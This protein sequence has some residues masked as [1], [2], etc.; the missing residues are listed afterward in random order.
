M[1]KLADLGTPRPPLQMECAIQA[2]LASNS[3]SEHGWYCSWTFFLLRHFS[4]D[5]FPAYRVLP[6][7]WLY[8]ACGYTSFARSERLSS[9]LCGLVT[10]APAFGGRARNWRAHAFIVG[11]AVVCGTR[12]CLGCRSGQHARRHRRLLI[13]SVAS[14]L[15][16]PAFKSVRNSLP[17]GIRVGVVNG[18]IGGNDRT[19]RNRCHRLVSNAWA[20]QRMH[21]ARSFQPVLLVTFVMSAI[22]FSVARLAHAR[23]AEALSRLRF[24]R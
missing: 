4:V 3:R 5:W 9:V 1:I 11:G 21:N 19:W 12:G 22:S 14:S 8:P 2:L 16:C 24:R 20:G 18:L 10:Q 17:A 15:F 7:G 13:A 6:W 23:H